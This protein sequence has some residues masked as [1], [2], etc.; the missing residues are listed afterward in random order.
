MKPTILI[1]P[2]SVDKE[3]EVSLTVRESNRIDTDPKTHRR[4]PTL[5][6]CVRAHRV[7]KEKGLLTLAIDSDLI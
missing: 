6:E 7:L 5:S 1:I 2:I 4:E 3:I